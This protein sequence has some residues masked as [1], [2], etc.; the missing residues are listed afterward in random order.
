M[1]GA[2]AGAL[3]LNVADDFEIARGLSGISEAPVIMTEDARMAAVSR[4]GLWGCVSK[5]EPEQS[6]YRHRSQD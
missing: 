5:R 6:Q 3:L 1:A 4:A 2:S